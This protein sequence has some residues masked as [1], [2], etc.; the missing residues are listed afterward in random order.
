MHK[1]VSVC[2]SLYICVHVL[3]SVCTYVGECVCVCG[4]VCVCVCVG[5]GV[6]VFFCG[7]QI[8]AAVLKGKRNCFLLPVLTHPAGSR[9][10]QNLSLDPTLIST[11][12]QQGLMG[13]LV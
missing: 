12:L 5:G 3:I 6:C 7:E 2:V 1:S 11:S 9:T 8:S 4:C 10:L 13:E